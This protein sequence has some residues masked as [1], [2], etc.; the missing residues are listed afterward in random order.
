MKLILSC[1][2]GGKEIPSAYTHL[3]S[4]AKGVLAT[5]RGYDP[6][7]LTL[8]EYL[9]ELADFSKSN[10]VSRLLIE[11]NRSLHHPRLFSEFTKACS[12]DIKDQLIATYYLPYRQSVEQAI[13]KEIQKGHT[14]L[15]LSLHSFTPQLAHTLR[16]CDIGLLY[17]PKRAEERIFCRR[18]KKE[19]LA[20]NDRLK[21][22]FN[23]PY[24][25]SAD[26]FTSFLRKKFPTQYLGIE[27][28]INQRHVVQ[29]KFPQTLKTQI[30]NSLKQLI[31]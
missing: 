26:G 13:A 10:S 30:K 29:N 9:K 24:L 28:E 14:V 4:E 1:E 23:Y 8:F 17:D 11:C 18:F 21:I 3:F 25:G 31:Y 20:E 19:L 27:L 15:H 12:K 6:G 16:N 22:R 2:H 7:T 5:H